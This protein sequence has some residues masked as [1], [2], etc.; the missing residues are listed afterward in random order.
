MS[1]VT[2]F[3]MLTVGEMVT[4][5]EITHKFASAMYFSKLD[6]KNWCWVSH[7][8]PRITV[9]QDIQHVQL[10]VRY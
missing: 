1:D 7:F 9:A 10:T 2:T 4:P 3:T 8:G 5:G 6:A